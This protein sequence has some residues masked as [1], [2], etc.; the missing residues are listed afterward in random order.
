MQEVFLRAYRNINSFDVSRKF[1]TWLYRVAHNFFINTIKKKG[2]E[3]VSFVDLDIFL[4]L[5]VTAPHSPETELMVAEERAFVNEHL[6]VL[7]PK[8]REPLILY[9]LE[10]LEYQE[11]AD[12]MHIPISTVGV[13]LKR[14]RE[15][16]K[17]NMLM[18]KEYDTTRK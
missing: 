13:R 7:S 10:Q 5:P 11:I 17:K 9:Y 12:V 3:H 14:A 18:S 15:L 8:Y 2:R 6:D 4:Q 1:S 16:L